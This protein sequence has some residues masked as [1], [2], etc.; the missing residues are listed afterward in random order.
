[1]LSTFILR[2]FQFIKFFPFFFIYFFCHF[3]RSSIGTFIRSHP[4]SDSSAT[5]SQSNKPQ[6]PQAPKLDYR[7]MVSIDDMP[8]LF[9]SFDS[10]YRKILLLLQLLSVFIVIFVIR[11]SFLFFS[12]NY[13]VSWKILLKN[14][15]KKYV[16]WLISF[17]KIR[18]SLQI[19]FNTS[20]RKWQKG[21]VS[22]NFS[23]LDVS[24]SL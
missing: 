10:K 13:F 8:A 2:T 16:F 12:F 11:F 21:K 1:M 20:S 14:V 19:M 22:A 18:K 23:R 3:R 5:S 6:K 7:S 9:V 15:K 24:K 17:L 4:S